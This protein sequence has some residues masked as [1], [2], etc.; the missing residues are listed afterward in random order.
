MRL[1]HWNSLELPVN[2]ILMCCTMVCA[3]NGFELQVIDTYGAENGV[4]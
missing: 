2:I 4:C 3:E 1:V